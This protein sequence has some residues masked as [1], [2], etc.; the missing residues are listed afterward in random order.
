MADLTPTLETFEKDPMT[1]EE[2]V[3]MRRV[4]QAKYEKSRLP[5][6]KDNNEFRTPLACYTAQFCTFRPG[7]RRNS[8]SLFVTS[9]RFDAKACAAIQRSL[10]PIISPFAS[11]VARIEP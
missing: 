2:M 6:L 10:F 1:A 3:W 5:L 7:T 11:R 4:C 9:V 8:R